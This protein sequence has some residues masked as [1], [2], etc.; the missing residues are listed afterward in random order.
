MAD[1]YEAMHT[2]NRAL[3]SEEFQN[4]FQLKT[5]TALFTYNHRV[6]HSRTT[7]E[8]SRVLRGCWINLEDWRGRVM[9]ARDRVNCL[10]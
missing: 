4:S 1:L 9:A 7:Y 5:G 8:G 2:F 10:D 6:L 3:Y